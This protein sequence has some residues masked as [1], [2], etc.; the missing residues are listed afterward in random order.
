MRKTMGEKTK[1]IGLE[2][3]TFDFAIPQSFWQE[4]Y[5]IMGFEPFGIVW[6]YDKYSRLFGRPFPVTLE[7]YINLKLC[8]NFNIDIPIPEK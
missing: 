8:Y 7:S 2:E 5:D 6:L 3:F 1:E 4:F